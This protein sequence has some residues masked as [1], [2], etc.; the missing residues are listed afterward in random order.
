MAI[1]RAGAA[2]A[3]ATLY[4]TLE[5]CAYRSVRGGVPCVERTLNAGIRRVVSAIEDP[6]PRIAGLGHALLRTAG[7]RV[8]AGLMADEAAR[9]HAGHFRRVREGCPHV[10]LKIARTADGFAGGPGRARVAIS[11]AEASAWVHLQRAH[12]DAIMIGWRRRWPTIRSS[13]CGCPA[14]SGA[15]PCAS[16]STAACAC[17]PT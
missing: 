3:G 17:G 10:T 7:V 4:V 12:H 1:D 16:C 13:P 9:I 6:N 5:P 15:R 14:W 8:T 2:A 11:C